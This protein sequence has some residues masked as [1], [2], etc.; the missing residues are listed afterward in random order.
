MQEE[1][2]TV[3]SNLED[4]FHSRVLVALE[5][6]VHAFRQLLMHGPESVRLSLKH[7]LK[8]TFKTRKKKMKGFILKHL[9]LHA[10]HV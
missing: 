6:R 1:C 3:L 5:V 10:M 2:A 4:V 9:T 8:H 7:K